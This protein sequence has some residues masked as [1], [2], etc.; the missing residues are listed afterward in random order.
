ML[1]I[2]NF[3]MFALLVCR[4]SV[5]QK[6][7]ELWD[8]INTEP[9]M[10]SIEK[11]KD[12]I[13]WNNPRLKKAIRMIIYF[14]EILPKKFLNINKGDNNLRMRIVSLTSPRNIVDNK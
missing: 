2:F 1:D 12:K 4:G 9:G 6:A 3:K 5:T 10:K 8:L 14:S 11:Y 7:Q 13:M